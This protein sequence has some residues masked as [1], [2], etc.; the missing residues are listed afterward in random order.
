MIVGIWFISQSFYM[1]AKARLAQ[2]L[3]D[4]SWQQASSD[5]LVGSDS[6]RLP[7]RPWWWADTRP[8]ARLEI[9]RLDKQLYVMQDSSGESLAFGP[10]HLPGSARP[11][12]F[13]HVMIAGHRDSHFAV[14]E[15]IQIGDLIDTQ[16]YQ[17]DRK[18]YRVVDLRV[19]DS[20]LESLH[21]L[22]SDQLTLITCYPFKDW[23]PGGPLRYIV[24]AEL[25]PNQAVQE[26]DR[27]SVRKYETKPDNAS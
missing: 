24:S 9:P 21:I 8:I 14:L 16:N 11:G 19:L 20:D 7:A 12:Q 22:S 5:A 1:T 13:G 2:F 26:N 27:G 10:G 6:T 18:R 4:Y 23:V 25:I 17:A 15:N 3:I